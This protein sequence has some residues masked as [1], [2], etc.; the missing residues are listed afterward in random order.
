[1]MELLPLLPETGNHCRVQIRSLRSAQC[2][3]AAKYQ[4]L[5]SSA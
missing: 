2:H 5:Q 3:T 4:K 1:V